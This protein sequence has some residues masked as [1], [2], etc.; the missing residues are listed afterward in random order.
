MAQ[1]FTTMNSTLWAVAS[2]S[3]YRKTFIPLVL[4]IIPGKFV[5][6][7]AKSRFVRKNDFR[8]NKWTTISP[9]KIERCRFSLNVVGGLLYAVGG[10][11]EEEQY[12]SCTC[13]CYNPV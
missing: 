2:I 7:Y 6:S 5:D 12:E 10:V 4:N 1:Q 13:E 8:G 9:M 3:L 11:S